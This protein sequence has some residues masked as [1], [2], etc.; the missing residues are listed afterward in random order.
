MANKDRARTAHAASRHVPPS[1]RAEK[2]CI[3]CGRPFSWRRRWT[4]VW[5]TVK[6]CS[7]ACRAK[8]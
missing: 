3:S 8:R 6:Y 5:S 2:I 4:R 7:E 1:L